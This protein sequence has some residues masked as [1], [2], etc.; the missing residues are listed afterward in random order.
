MIPGV[1]CLLYIVWTM[2]QR[3]C[4]ASHVESHVVSCMKKHICGFYIVYQ[5]LLKVFDACFDMY[6]R[7]TDVGTVLK[8]QQIMFDIIT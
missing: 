7:V 3:I 8:L 4:A 2:C 6:G 5:L 1:L